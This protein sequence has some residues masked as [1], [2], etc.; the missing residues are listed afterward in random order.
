MKMFNTT[1]S[2]DSAIRACKPKADVPTKFKTA[3]GKCS[4]N[5]IANK[6]DGT[7]QCFCNDK[8]CNAAEANG[9]L[10]TLVI[11]NSR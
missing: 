8:K 4:G 3:E 11:P 2:T 10:F 7:T 9:P 5:C 1:G 6:E